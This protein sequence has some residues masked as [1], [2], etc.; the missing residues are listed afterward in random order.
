M[1]LC[2]ALTTITPRRVAASHVDV[3]EADAGAADHHQLGA[4]LQHLG[5][6]LRGG[7]D[8]ERVRALHRL[9]QAGQIELDLHFVPGR[10]QPV[11]A[12]FGD[13]FGDQDACHCV[14]RY[15]TAT[16]DRKCD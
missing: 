14:H 10:A 4:C 5:G 1:L 13:L 7:A 11:E 2:G 12:T 8:D 9:E 3:V 16:R 6:D 15:R